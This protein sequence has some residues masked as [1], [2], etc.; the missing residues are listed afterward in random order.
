M[1]GLGGGCH[2]CTEAVF[3]ALQ[4]VCKVEQ[5]YIKSTPPADSFS[6][7]VQLTFDTGLIPEIV[8]IEVHLR[9]HAS[10][11]KH[12]FRDKYR[13]A[14]YVYNDDQR[15][16]VNA[17]LN[18]LQNEF[19]AELITQVLPFDEFRFSAVR[20]HRFYEKQVSRQFCTRYIDP[21]LEL[22]RARY[23]DILLPGWKCDSDPKESLEQT[24]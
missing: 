9:T 1:I 23:Q 11:S 7:A 13:S 19:P 16:R 4:G 8:L 2:W 24:P 10:T 3:S 12:S 5:G 20:Y 21:K 14:I 17:A 15:V 22:L 18:A 6:E